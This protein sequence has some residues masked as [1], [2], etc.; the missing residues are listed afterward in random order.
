MVDGKS[1]VAEKADDATYDEVMRPMASR[2]NADTKSWE[3]SDDDAPLGGRD[4]AWAA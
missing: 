4:G 3:G 2:P 1:Y